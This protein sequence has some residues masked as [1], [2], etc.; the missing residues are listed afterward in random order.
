MLSTFIQGLPPPSKIFSKF[1]WP[2]DLVQ[3]GQREQW[4]RS[5]WV[6]KFGNVSGTRWWVQK[7]QKRFPL[8]LSMFGCKCNGLLHFM[9]K[10]KKIQFPFSCSISSYFI[11]IFLRNSPLSNTCNK[12][13]HG[14]N[15][16]RTPLHWLQETGSPSFPALR[17][18]P[19]FVS[20][21]YSTIFC[22]S[23]SSLV[24]MIPRVNFRD[25][26]IYI[27]K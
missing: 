19:E 7:V 10:K 16:R 6:R 27:F 13:G 3:K 22:L 12:Y 1:S 9:R 23:M 14:G 4:H 26:D 24:R 17:V 21:L 20:K 25:W 11:L 15:S 5:T 2:K 18:R 8:V